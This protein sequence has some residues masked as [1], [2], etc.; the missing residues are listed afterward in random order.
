MGRGPLLSINSTA[1]EKKR[2]EGNGVMRRWRVSNLEYV[3]ESEGCK[4]VP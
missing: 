3:F 2:K 1:R 4:R